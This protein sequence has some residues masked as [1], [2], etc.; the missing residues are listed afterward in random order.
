MSDTQDISE[1]VGSQGAI[2]IQAD[3]A[4]MPAWLYYMPESWVIDCWELSST[5]AISSKWGKA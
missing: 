1:F 5:H 4:A 3:V 2:L